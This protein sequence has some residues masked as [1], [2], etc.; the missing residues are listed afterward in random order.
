MEE[1]GQCTRRHD[2]WGQH[3]STPQCSVED[4]FT[5][6]PKHCW[7]R[8]LAVSSL[9]FESNQWE[10]VLQWLLN[11]LSLRC[12]LY[13]I[14]RSSLEL[15]LLVATQLATRSSYVVCTSTL[16]S[17]AWNHGTTVQNT[18][19]NQVS[20]KNSLHLQRKWRNEITI[21]LE[22]WHLPSIVLGSKVFNNN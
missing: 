16:N 14:N 13:S 12:V 4:Q 5:H 8:S 21:S 20:V 2:S 9:W 10:V 17:F 22:P 7:F 3:A 11:Y 19:E 15:L 18:P 1:K 6:S